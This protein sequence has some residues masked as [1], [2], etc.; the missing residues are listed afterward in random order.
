M[1]DIDDDWLNDLID[2]LDA[3]IRQSSGGQPWADTRFLSWASR[4]ATAQAR[5]N[6]EL[7]PAPPRPL[8]ALDQLPPFTT[9]TFRYTRLS[10]FATDRPPA[11]ELLT[12]GTTSRH[13]GVHRLYRTEIY[14][15]SAL[16]AYDRLVAARY[17]TKHLVS[18]VPR[19]D[20]VPASSLSFMVD[21]FVDHRFG[22]RVTYGVRHHGA[23]DEGLG[24][25]LD[26]LS[27]AGAPV[28]LFATTLAAAALLETDVGAILPHG[29]LILTTGGSKGIRSS[30]DPTE[31]DAAL[32]ERFPG[33]PVG[34]EYGMTELLSQAYRIRSDAFELPPW[35]RVMAIDPTTGRRQPHGASGLLR[36]VDLANV[37]SALCV[38]TADLGRTLSEHQFVYEGRAVGAPLRGCSLTFEE[39]QPHRRTST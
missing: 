1:A 24:G 38:Q 11:L 34:A 17:P 23:L 39:L 26:H 5:A 35:C 10:P 16:I 22:G 20:H 13:R 2:A 28:L 29:S 32:A 14:R 15:S 36:F 9:D 8:E 31:V 19:H 4:I 6:P 37:Q 12:S 18:L 25:N 7:Y 21:C 30:V 27:R 3:E 33:T